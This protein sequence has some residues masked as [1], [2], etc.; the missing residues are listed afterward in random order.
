MPFASC[1]RRSLTQEIHSLGADNGRLGR[2]LHNFSPQRS[3]GQTW[4][5][6]LFH[7]VTKLGEIQ[8]YVL[9]STINRRTDFS[10]LASQQQHQ[11]SWL[12]LFLASLLPRVTWIPP[13]FVSLNIRIASE[14]VNPAT[15]RPFTENISSPGKHCL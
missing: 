8:Q 15:D 10:V 5:Q 7:R 12:A 2:V 13:T 6:V 9:T 4:G 3:Q 11:Q 1:E 14:W